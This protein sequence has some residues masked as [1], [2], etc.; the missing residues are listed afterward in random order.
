[1]D[2]VAASKWLNAR[3]YGDP[4]ERFCSRCYRWRWLPWCAAI[5]LWIDHEARRVHGEGPGHCRRANEA[6]R[7]GASGK[8]LDVV[9][10]ARRAGL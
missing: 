9:E 10:R 1:M 6:Q 8:V 3:L 4:D 7:A 5:V 2:D